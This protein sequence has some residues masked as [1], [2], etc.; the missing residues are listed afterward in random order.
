MNKILLVG[1]GGHCRSCI[2]VIEAQGRYDIKGIVQPSFIKGEAIFNYPVVGCDD[3]LPKLLQ[4]CSIALITVGQ[5]KSPKIRTYLFNHLVG[6]GAELPIIASPSSNQSSY[7]KIGGGTI[8]MHGSIVN[9]GSKIG[10]NCIINSQALIE[11]DVIVNSHCHIS[12]GA[13]IN[14]SV[15][16][17]EG[18]FIGSGA[19]LKEGVSIGKNVVVGAGE[20]V[21]NDVD[22]NTVVRKNHV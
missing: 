4:Q 1:G 11:H 5:I 19:V 9:S 17:G 20:I 3:D 12:T 22:D 15:T 2:D 6:L 8:L 13:L 18:S 7:S 21:L 16:I 14:G 10:H